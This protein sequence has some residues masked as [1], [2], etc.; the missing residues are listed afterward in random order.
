M[1]T[2]YHRVIFNKSRGCMMAVS[3][4]ASSAG[5]TKSS[6]SRQSR[7]TCCKP[8]VL[9]LTTI[10]LAGVFRIVDI[11]HVLPIS[12]TSKLNLG[13]LTYQKEPQPNQ[14]GRKQLRIM[15]RLIA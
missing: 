7:A 2:H 5:K 15:W 1:N 4:V 6:K 8:R 11:D 10:T 13:N 12:D 14:Y 9:W 3:E